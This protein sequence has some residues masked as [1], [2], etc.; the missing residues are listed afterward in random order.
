VPVQVLAP[1]RAD[2]ARRVVET[3]RIKRGDTLGAIAR[4]W[5]PQGVTLNQMM[6]ALYQGNPAVFIRDNINL[7]RAGATLSIPYREEVAA[8]DTSKASQQVKLQMSEFARYRR[9]QA[10]AVSA[11]PAKPVQREVVTG[12]VGVRKAARSL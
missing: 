9:Q 1:Q 2:P 7:I 11:A 12:R 8:I 6:V 3:Y 10:A 4:Y 5:K